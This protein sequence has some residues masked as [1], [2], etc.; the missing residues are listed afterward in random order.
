MENIAKLAQAKGLEGLAAGAVGLVGGPA[1]AGPGPAAGSGPT[2][3]IQVTAGEKKNAVI[4]EICN[5]V[6]GQK[7]II[8]DEF[9]KQIKG[10]FQET[11]KTNSPLGEKMTK[12]SQDVIQY[13]IKSSL[14]DNY[15]VQ[16]QMIIILYGELGATILNNY[17]I[18]HLNE[19]KDLQN[20]S[21]SKILDELLKELSRKEEVVG[22]QGSSVATNLPI[23]SEPDI[24]SVGGQVLQKGGTEPATSLEQLLRYFPADGN[25]KYF[26]SKMAHIIEKGI[27]DA[28][29]ETLQSQDIKMLIHTQIEGHVQKY[30]SEIITKFAGEDK[31]D[32]AIKLKKM[33]LYTLLHKKVIRRRFKNAIE[34]AI[35]LCIAKTNEGEPSNN[36]Q[37]NM[38]NSMIEQVHI[39]FSGKKSGGNTEEV[40]ITGVI[41]NTLDQE[42]GKTKGKKINKRKTKKHKTNGRS[43]RL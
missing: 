8:E 4:E 30:M 20:L 17:F 43:R 27:S 10:F 21:S 29:R 3:A 28:V 16:H 1:G 18:E 42:G 39:F 14:L 11:L 23:I 32:N 6:K 19:K 37:Q 24:I 36:I 33:M 12:L 38:I 9:K 13:E 7:G 41:G 5:I 22:G 35:E 2:A 31:T 40:S 26:N 34:K 15:F 25:A